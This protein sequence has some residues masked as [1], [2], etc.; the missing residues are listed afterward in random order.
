MGSRA[1]IYQDEQPHH[2][3][4][5]G[6]A[7]GQ[8][9]SVARR[10]DPAGH[11]REASARA[12]DPV[13][14]AIRRSRH[15]VTVISVSDRVVIGRADRIAFE[16]AALEGIGSEPSVVLDLSR[17]EFFEPDGV[18]GLLAVERA[19][20]ER[21]GRLVLAGPN[22]AVRELFQLSGLDCLFKVYPSVERAVLAPLRGSSGPERRH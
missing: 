13:F 20:T 7:P 5:V 22:G 8:G 3:T 4:A 17:I 14:A 10:P 1:Y 15:G 21:N 6:G 18:D 16:R 9:G 12:A 2:S 19:I 11:R